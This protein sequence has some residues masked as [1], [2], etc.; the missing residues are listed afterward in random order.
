MAEGAGAIHK[1]GK[2]GVEGL[3]W[4][5]WGGGVTCSPGVGDWELGCGGGGEGGVTAAREGAVTRGEGAG[6][7][8]GLLMPCQVGFL[9]GPAG[10]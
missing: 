2:R 4:G 8:A 1:M 9:G 10:Y 3:P 6:S 7:G 5:K